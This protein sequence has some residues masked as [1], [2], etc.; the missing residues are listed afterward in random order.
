[1]ARQ[2]RYKIAPAIE[3]VCTYFD[4]NK[5]ALLRHAGVPADALDDPSKGL[6]EAQFF[7][8][9]QGMFEVSDDPDLAVKIGKSF[10]R[11]VTIPAALA[12]C[13]SRNVGEGV[14]RLADF[15][16]LIA[17]VALET[18]TTERGFEITAVFA[19]GRIATP[20]MAMFEI[21]Y[22]T[23]MMRNSVLPQ[24]DPLS[25]SMPQA[26]AATTAARSLL[27][28]PIRE[29]RNIEIVLRH[30]DATL[31]LISAN[32]DLLDQVQMDLNHK[33]GQQD[34]QALT[35]E[36]VKSAL[37]ELLPAGNPTIEAV[38]ERLVI[39]RRSLQRKLKIEGRSFQELLSETRE[40]MSLKYLRSG[41]MS[42]EEISYLLAYRDP[43]SFYRAFH[44]WTGMTPAEARRAVLQ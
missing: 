37:V 24:L 41:E 16:P 1:M 18:A 44:G 25:V 32:A 15:K 28:C 33:M 11:A 23:E 13:A 4:L 26:G 29:S 2:F 8:V 12:Y 5:P 27:N 30:S 31:P 35:S 40:A 14:R 22:L 36:R 9:W 43:N 39:T 21:V 7:R 42:V 10:A 3:Q 17:P 20:S 6:T 19:G 38:C 34:G